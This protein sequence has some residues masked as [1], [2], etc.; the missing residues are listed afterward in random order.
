[1]KKNKNGRNDGRQKPNK[2]GKIS[3]SR[4]PK[5]AAGED[6][7]DGVT[8]AVAVK[9]SR[10]T[11]QT[12]YASVGGKGGYFFTS[13]GWV[14]GNSEGWAIMRALNEIL[15]ETP[16]SS[17]L[18]LCGE[19]PALIEKVFNGKHY[20]TSKVVTKDTCLIHHADAFDAWRSTQ[21]RMRYK[22]VIRA[23]PDDSASLRARHNVAQ[24]GLEYEIALDVVRE[25]CRLLR[26]ASAH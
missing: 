23:K 20:W 7:F 11:G 24:R 4:Q 8:V 1:M 2:F 21:V 15:S 13:H 6:K 14:A 17:H 25:A 26:D 16:D 5:N 12:F 22:H 18:R 9:F 3:G 19:D 10:K